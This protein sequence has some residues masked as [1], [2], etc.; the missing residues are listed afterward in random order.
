MTGLSE[1]ALSRRFVADGA[2]VKTVHSARLGNGRSR[3]TARTPLYVSWP[4]YLLPETPITRATHD[5]NFSGTRPQCGTATTGDRG[6]L[7]RW[8]AAMD[9]FGPTAPDGRL[10][11]RSPRPAVLDDES[12]SRWRVPTMATD[13]AGRDAVSKDVWAN[14]AQYEGYVGRWSRLVAAEFLRRLDPPPGWPGS[15]SAAA[16]ACSASDPA[17]RRPGGAGRH[18][19]VRGLPRVRP[20]RRGR[21]RP[22][23]ASP[24]ATPTIC[25]STTGASTPPSAAWCSTSYRRP[26][27]RRRGDVRVTRPGGLIAAY[28]WDYAEGMQLMR[29]SGRRRRARPGRR[30]RSARPGGSRCAGPDALRALFTRR[31]LSACRRRGDRRSDGLRRLR[32]LLEPVPQRAGTG[33]RVRHVPEQ[34]CPRRFARAH[35]RPPARLAGRLDPA[36]RPGLGGPRDPRRTPALGR[37]KRKW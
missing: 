5:G 9:G 21:R 3:L 17:V 33:P 15:T 29:H 31:R 23:S 30:R 4:G 7:L 11:G 28:V 19:P 12:R 36:D 37:R 14:G 16:P 34:G 20:P 27:P 10:P 6:T 35:P 8:T 1:S 18:R 25:T 24:R 32:R 22:R 2:R 13:A 26:E